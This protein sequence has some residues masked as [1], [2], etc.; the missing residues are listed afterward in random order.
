MNRRSCEKNNWGD[1]TITPV[2][3]TLCMHDKVREVS[4]VGGDVRTAKSREPYSQELTA[5]SMM[6]CLSDRTMM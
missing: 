6:V 2:A 4:L 3:S 1:G 5:R